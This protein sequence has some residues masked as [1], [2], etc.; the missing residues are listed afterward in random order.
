MTGV[1]RT[2]AG[3]EIQMFARSFRTILALAD[4]L[5]DLGALEQTISETQQKASVLATYLDDLKAQVGKAKE[6]L[7]EARRQANE[8][9]AL[10]DTIVANART[11]AE[12]LAQSARETVA[13][14]DKRAAQILDKAEI[15][16]KNTTNN[17]HETAEGIRATIQELNKEVNEKRAELVKLNGLLTSMRD[18]LGK[19]V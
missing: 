16:G 11:E 12:V 4:E 14:A 17:F 15:A 6:E 7:G 13:R 3:R 19:L 8:A 18:S 1:E 10:A 9:Q 5:V 2:K